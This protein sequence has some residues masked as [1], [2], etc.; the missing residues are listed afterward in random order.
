MLYL[1]SDVLW[2]MMPSSIV[3][4]HRPGNLECRNIILPV[5]KL[6]VQEIHVKKYSETPK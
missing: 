2:D 6:Q 4:S 1:T 5:H 3:S